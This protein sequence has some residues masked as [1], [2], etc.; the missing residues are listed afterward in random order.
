MYQCHFFYGHIIRNIPNFRTALTRQSQGGYLC[1][2]VSLQ[3][4]THPK[5]D[6]VNFVEFPDLKNI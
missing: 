3:R 5:F 1:L 2:E 4:V 6:D